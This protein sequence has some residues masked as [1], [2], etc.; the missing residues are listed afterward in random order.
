MVVA[1]GRWQVLQWWSQRCS[2]LRALVLTNYKSRIIPEPLLCALHSIP[3]SHFRLP[4]TTHPLCT[5]PSKRGSP[6]PLYSAPYSVHCL[7]PPPAT[8]SYTSLP[9]APYFVL[10]Q[11]TF[12]SPSFYPGRGNGS[13]LLGSGSKGHILRPPFF[14][15]CST[16]NL[17]PSCLLLTPYISS[18]PTLRLDLLTYLPTYSSR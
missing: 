3:V 16:S 7:P 18:H 2:K 10:L 14:S 9:P 13:P 1:G 17:P 6:L 5:S 15:L 4:I 8:Y 11:V 12:P